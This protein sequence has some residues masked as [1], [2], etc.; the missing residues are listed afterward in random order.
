VKVRR[1]EFMEGVVHWCFNPV[2]VGMFTFYLGVASV[3]VMLIK[4]GLDPLLGYGII[5][6]TLVAVV[7]IS[8]RLNRVKSEVPERIACF[9]QMSSLSTALIPSLN[10]IPTEAV[11]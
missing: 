5:G 7:L 2:L 8:W 4:G 10:L 11:T 1:D 3:V 9:L 6:G